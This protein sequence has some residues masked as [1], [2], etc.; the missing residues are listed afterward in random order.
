MMKKRFLVLVDYSPASAGLL[1]Y[2]YQWSLHTGAELML[3]HHTTVMMPVLTDHSDKQALKKLANDEALERLKGFARETLPELVRISC[4]ASEAP[5]LTTLAKL[6]KE[7]YEHL[8]FLGLKG[9]GPVKKLF[10]GSTAVRVIEN[11]GHL[12]AAIPKNTGVFQNTKV[13]VAIHDKNPLNIIGFNRFLSFLEDKVHQLV[14]FTITKPEDDPGPI[15]RYLQDL[16]DMYKGSVGATYEMYNGHDLL[17]NI[18]SIISHTPG[19]LLVL[20][21]GPRLLSDHYFRKFVINELI[22]D[23]KTPLIVLP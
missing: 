12:V 15:E 5:L 1:R 23:G 20:Q 9:T 3:V 13:Y 8:V 16:R 4:V 21:K 6:L 11:T 14:F 22:Y 17:E 10:F 19:Q 7:P 2:A 18:K